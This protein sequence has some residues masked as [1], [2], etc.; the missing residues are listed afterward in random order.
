MGLIGNELGLR[1]DEARRTGEKVIAHL[2]RG[3]YEAAH[4]AISRAEFTVQDKPNS[5]LGNTPLAQAEFCTRT[6]NL[7]ERHGVITFGDLAKKVAAKGEE[8]ILKVPGGGE[9][10]LHEVQQILHY[11]LM[12]RK[13]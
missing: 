3:N 8:W 1:P 11:E 2:I 4:V 9:G 13:Q 12:R 7:M 6:L 5:T 10:T